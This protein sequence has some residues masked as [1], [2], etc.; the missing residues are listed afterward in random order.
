MKKIRRTYS[1][2]LREPGDLLS[3]EVK[4]VMNKTSGK[5]ML[6]LEGEIGRLSQLLYMTL[7]DVETMQNKIDW[8]ERVLPRIERM[9]RDLQECYE[10]LE[11]LYHRVTDPE[12]PIRKAYMDEHYKKLGVVIEEV[13]E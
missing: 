1:L 8:Y 12:N 5:D 4:E 2:E 7:L 13:A 11:K 9:Y 3:D 10:A 6:I